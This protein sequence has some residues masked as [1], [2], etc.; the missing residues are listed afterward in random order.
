MR[1]NKFMKKLGALIMC[2]CIGATSVNATDKSRHD[3]ET[4]K[5]SPEGNRSLIHITTTNIVYLYA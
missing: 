5:K 4:T 2:L 1:K 3:N